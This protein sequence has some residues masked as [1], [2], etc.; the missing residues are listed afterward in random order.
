MGKRFKGFLLKL[1]PALLI[2]L[3]AVVLY[4]QTQGIN[5]DYQTLENTT[6]EPTMAPPALA[7]RPT[8][9][10]FRVGSIGPEVIAFQQRLMD[11]GYY[12]GE[13]DGK[14]YE[15]TQ[16]AVKLFQAQHNL[17]ADGIAGQKTL[18]L[19]NSQEAKP[20]SN[21]SPSPP[22]QPLDGSYATPRP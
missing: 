10:I 3:V 4:M 11:L 6:P 12:Q 22:P 7:F 17:E 21:V 18:A 13:L 9:T 5:R 15:G 19:L 16:M 20:Y 14:Y 2:L 1:L 8:E